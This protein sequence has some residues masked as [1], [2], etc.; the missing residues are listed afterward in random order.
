MTETTESEKVRDNIRHTIR[1]LLNHTV[2]NGCTEK[3]AYNA[4]EKVGK[5]LKIYNLSMSDIFLEKQECIKKVVSIG[6]QRRHPIS[7]SVI[8]IAN[9][10]DCKAWIYDGDYVFFGLE[11]DVEMAAYLFDNI[12]KA[13][14]TELEVFKK[15]DTYIKAMAHRKSISVSFQ[16][17]MAGRVS[18]RLNAMTNTRHNEESKVQ[19]PHLSPG[20]SIVLLKQNKVEADFEKLG[21]RLRKTYSKNRINFS[22]YSAGQSAGNKVNLNRPIGDQTRPTPLLT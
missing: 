6:R 21:M 13:M 4:A 7:L 11:N 12:Y 22:G 16:K 10:C 14:D 5:L 1:N 20:T 2:E 19:I 17:G 15:S 8:A 3:A 9:F 18:D